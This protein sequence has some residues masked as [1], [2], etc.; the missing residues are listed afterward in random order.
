MTI[1]FFVFGLLPIVKETADSKTEYWKALA[2][3][4]SSQIYRIVS[5]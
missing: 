3:V 5:E 2:L 1:F 4:L